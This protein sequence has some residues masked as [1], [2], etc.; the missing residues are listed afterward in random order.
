MHSPGG[1]AL[2]LSLST[3]AL[4]LPAP[5]IGTVAAAHGALTRTLGRDSTSLFSISLSPGVTSST[6][7]APPGGGPLTVVAPT[8]VDAVTVCAH[9]LRSTLNASFA[10]PGAGGN[11]LANLPAS[12]PLPAPAG[13]PLALLR[14][15]PYTYYMNVV[16]NSYSNVWWNASRWQAEVDWM[17][18]HGV[19]VALAYG[20][21]E[22]LFKATYESFGVTDAQLATFFNGPAYL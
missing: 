4:G 12:G 10:W 7:S 3:A 13:G 5:P 6:L 9:Y 16:Q 20:G 21:Q 8:A 19:N 1:F 18:L 17:M 14:A 2:L 11:Q 22:A 15:V